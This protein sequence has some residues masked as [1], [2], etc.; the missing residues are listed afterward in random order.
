MTEFIDVGKTFRKYMA[1]KYR[2]H[3][4]TRQQMKMKELGVLTS[5]CLDSKHGQN[6]KNFYKCMNQESERQLSV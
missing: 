4:I 5:V 3:K 6:T 1:K 2:T